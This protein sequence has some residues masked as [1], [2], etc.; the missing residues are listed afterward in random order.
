MF[1]LRGIAVSLT[2]FVVLYCLLSLMVVLAWR[3][4]KLLHTK[5]ERSLANVLFGLRILPMAASA[6]ITL[7]LVV[8]S[9]QLLEPR[10]IEED[11]GLMP[12][13]LGLCALLLIAWG[14][15]RVVTAQTRTSRVVARW[16]DG[17]NPHIVEKEVVTFCSKRDVP[18]LTLVGVCK[19]RVLVSESTVSLL[20]RQELCIALKHEIA[21]VR[22]HDNLK[23]LVFRFSPFPGMVRM[24]RAWS[25]AAELAADDAAVSNLDD[26]VDL[27]AALVKLSLL[28]PVEA[29]PAC[30]VG[31]VTGSIHARVARLLAW[32]E[33]IRS[34]EVRSHHWY[35]IPPAVAAL[36]C[37]FAIYGPALTVTHEITEWIVS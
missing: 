4:L 14:V 26:A 7:G 27:A 20:S 32:D 8:P 36:L 34:K 25:Q 12:L 16:M 11:M 17:A 3:S 30:T 1:A 28:V 29:A 15:F 5:S 13:V 6:L 33:V 2:F 24:E 10:S 21:H 19:P 31:F 35:A 23:K 22:S 37:V 9:F 18:P